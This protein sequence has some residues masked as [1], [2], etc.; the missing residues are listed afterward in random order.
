MGCFWCTQLWT[1]GFQDPRPPPPP[2]SPPMKEN[3][4][5][6]EETLDLRVMLSRWRCDR[7][8]SGMSRNVNWGGGG[9]GIGFKVQGRSR[10]GAQA[11]GAEQ[12]CRTE[13]SQNLRQM[14]TFPDSLVTLT[15]LVQMPVGVR[16]SPPPPHPH[17]PGIG[18]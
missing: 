7:G 11:T 9:G 10:A 1:S 13:L 4:G 6:Q 2:H 14:M 8:P 16:W 12:I 18:W 15:R 5:D 3:S 17:H